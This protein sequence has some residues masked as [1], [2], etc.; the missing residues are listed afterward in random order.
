VRLVGFLEPALLA[1]VQRRLDRGAWTTCV[2]S[3]LDPPAV[4][5]S[6]EDDVLA[7]AMLALLNDRALLAAARAITGVAEIRSFGGRVY[8]MDPG[9][10]HHDTW[11][12]DMD[13]QRLVALSINLS[14]GVF[15]G[16]ELAL[17]RAG[18]DPP[19]FSIANTGPGDAILFRLG[20]DLEHRVG[21][22]HGDE[23]KIAYAGW[24]GRT[25]VELAGLP[26]AW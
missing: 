14:R 9:P 23:P 11:H 1:W 24:F 21:P 13:G 3:A 18:A 12:S 6:F 20:D 17:R 7:G 8:R 5:L 10:A 2:H 16:G 25:P 4:D 22:V 15:A 19:L 26:S